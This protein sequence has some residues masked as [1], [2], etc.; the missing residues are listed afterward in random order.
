[1]AGSRHLDVADVEHF[2]YLGT[3]PGGLGSL[4]YHPFTIAGW[5][6]VPDDQ[7]AQCLFSIVDRSSTND[8]YYA[9]CQGDATSGTQLYSS[10][11]DTAGTTERST[12]DWFAAD[13]NHA[14]VAVDADSDIEA[15][16]NGQTDGQTASSRTPDNID[17]IA[18]GNQCNAGSN[19]PFDGFLAHWA[20]WDE[21]LSAAEI[22]ALARGAS[23][24]KVR[25]PTSLL[26][27][28]PFWEEGGGD[29]AQDLIGGCNLSP[30]RTSTVLTTASTG[31]EGVDSG[32][33][34]ELWWP[35]KGRKTFFENIAAAPADTPDPSWLHRR[36]PRHEADGGEQRR[37]LRRQPV[38]PAGIP[39][40]AWIQRRRPAPAPLVEALRRNRQQVP[41]G[42]APADVPDVAWL[43][44][45]RRI[46]RPAADRPFARPVIFP[47]AR[48][49]PPPAI[50]SRRLRVLEVAERYP[51]PITAIAGPLPAAF[52]QPPA[53]L[54]RRRRLHDIVTEV[55]ARARTQPV[56]GLT[57]T[58]VPAPAM[59]QRRR[60][61][62]ES[63][64]LQEHRPRRMLS[65]PVTSPTPVPGVTDAWLHVNT[66]RH[67]TREFS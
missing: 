53:A 4:P 3:L 21:V 35:G 9:R 12:F 44:R 7:T 62:P 14:A 26:C 32:P 24:L 64:P 28:W 1:M 63:S 6:K 45:R 5:F 37:A 46:D 25:R 2:G 48:Q 61:A 19:L 10:I 16:I 36:R 29:D 51:R 15:F 39:D 8:Y 66:H 11:T 47:A 27:Y 52:T 54:G 20:L 40:V 23:P 43:Q 22:A 42:V 60:P 34:I 55:L 38:L 58:V 56:P 18:F 13:W 67:R 59:L 31:I 33:P 57:P 41:A 49:A 30:Y 50:L 65:R 17:T